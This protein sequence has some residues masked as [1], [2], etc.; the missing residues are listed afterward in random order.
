LWTV[1]VLASALV[2]K[3]LVQGDAVKLTV[4]VL[5]QTRNPDVTNLYGFH[6]RLP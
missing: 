1:R 5:I 4:G 2:G 6:D 3:N